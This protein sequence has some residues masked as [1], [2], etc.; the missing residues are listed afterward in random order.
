MVNPQATKL[1]PVAETA[2]TS[3]PTHFLRRLFS[4]MDNELRQFQLY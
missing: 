1:L 3:Q 2:I 4:L